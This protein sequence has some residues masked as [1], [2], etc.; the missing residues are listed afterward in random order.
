M[1]GTPTV[2]PDGSVRASAT[3]RNPL[4]LHARPAALIVRMLAHYDA[5]VQVNGVNAA[6]VLE[7]MKLGAVRD[8]VLTVTAQGPQASE[9]VERLVADVEAGFGEV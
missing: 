4:G 2:A 7:L 8:D 3:L 5:K 1:P 6:S 9:A